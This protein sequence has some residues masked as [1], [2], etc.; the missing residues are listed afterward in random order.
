M[1]FALIER[2]LPDDVTAMIAKNLHEKYLADIKVEKAFS[3]YPNGL[4][5]AILTNDPSVFLKKCKVK[6]ENVH[7]VQYSHNTHPIVDVIIPLCGVDGDGEN[8]FIMWNHFARANGSPFED[9]C[10]IDLYIENNMIKINKFYYQSTQ[11]LPLS[12]LYFHDTNIENDEEN[13]EIYLAP[14]MRYMKQKHNLEPDIDA[15]YKS[16]KIWL[17]GAGVCDWLIEHTITHN[18]LFWEL[19]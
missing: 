7:V 8:R 1:A 9:Q 17:D 12:P 19:E 2:Y 10:L 18:K 14:F 4:E 6:F 13:L 3:S 5:M 16:N 15:S 11:Q